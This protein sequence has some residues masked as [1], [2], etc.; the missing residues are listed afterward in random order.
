MRPGSQELVFGREHFERSGVGAGATFGEA[1][2][3]KTDRP[4][5]EQRRSH[6]M[7]PIVAEPEAQ[8]HDDQCSPRGNQAGPVVVFFVHARK[9]LSSHGRWV[10]AVGRFRGH[11]LEDEPFHPSGL[12]ER[13]V[14]IR[15]AIGMIVRLLVSTLAFS[16]VMHMSACQQDDL[17][18]EDLERI[19]AVLEHQRDAWNRGDLE[20][21]MQGY[22]RSPD[23]VFTSGGEIRRGWQA[24]FD[25][26]RSRY[27]TGQDMGTLA[28][29][30]LEI[31]PLG[32]AA[33]VVLGH[34]K[35][36]STERAGAGVFTLVVEQR[37]GRWV[38]VHDHTSAKARP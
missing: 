6:A 17:S 20:T 9:L 3:D 38:I 19:R 35:L 14:S 23:T 29:S 25:S 36:S 37:N 27:G 16:T 30:E 18:R 5:Q 10:L 24:T 12:F 32:D 15:Y 22:H 33:A 8:T 4:H 34:W 26:Y 21:Y 2:D 1:V 7:G 28:F 31:R 13:V 11:D